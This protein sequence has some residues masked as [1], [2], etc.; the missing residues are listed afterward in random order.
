ME[1][2]KIS[3]QFPGF[4]TGDL[5]VN[6][7]T[8]LMGQPMS[9]KTTL[10]RLV[11]DV[12]YASELGVVPVEAS[13]IAKEFL[14]GE[15]KVSVGKRGVSGVLTCSTFEGDP[16]CDYN[17]E[18][19]GY[20]GVFFPSDMEYILKYNYS[21]VYY[22]S[23]SE[24]FTVLNKLRA[25]VE[26]KYYAVKLQKGFIKSRLIARD[27]QLYE[28]VGGKQ[29]R[30][31]LASSSSLKLSF[32]VSLLEKGLLGDPKSTVLLFDDVQE[33]LH[34]EYML[35]LAYL[36]GLMASK[37]YK[38]LLTTHNVGFLSLL[39]CLRGVAKTLGYNDEFGLAPALYVVKDKHI[40]EYSVASSAI[41]TY[42]E[43][44]LSV[45]KNCT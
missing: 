36:L 17:K 10:L 23:Y 9:G 40:E 27:F 21:P 4:I 2:L 37:G 11:Y 16:S 39:A 33:G 22:E 30:A 19:V 25:K 38:I 35:R 12:L 31:E 3:V 29:F 44:S 26:D 34:A 1:P 15:M 6:G 43:Y 5:E 18:K 14:D 8:V 13:V 42:T 45:Y 28:E 20:K 41:P 32:L 24:F 7:I